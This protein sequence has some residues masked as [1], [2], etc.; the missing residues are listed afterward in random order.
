MLNFEDESIMREREWFETRGSK[1]ANDSWSDKYRKRNKIMM[2]FSL[3]LLY[4][5][6]LILALMLLRLKRRGVIY[7]EYMGQFRVSIF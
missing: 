6:L 4:S 7:F 2:I 1:S 3:L 5:R